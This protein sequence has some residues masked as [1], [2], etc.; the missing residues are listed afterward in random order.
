[1]SLSIVLDLMNLQQASAAASNIP[2]ARQAEHR[3]GD[4][5]PG[6]RERANNLAPAVLDLRA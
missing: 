1:M 6:S 4:R 2:K 5:V 3:A